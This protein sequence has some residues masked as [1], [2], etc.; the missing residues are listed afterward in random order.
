MVA[1]VDMQALGVRRAP[2]GGEQADDR[3]AA[4]QRPA[5]GTRG[6]AQRIGRIGAARLGGAQTGDRDDR[7]RPWPKEGS[8]VTLVLP[9]AGAEVHQ[10]G[11]EPAAQQ[12]VHRLRAGW[13]AA[14]VGAPSTGD[15]D[16]V[17]VSFSSGWSVAVIVGGTARS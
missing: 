15:D 11:Q 6:A 17:S 7:E 1:L 16:G 14:R 9:A 12:P 13:A 4:A 8:R 3:A 10:G 5:G 2:H